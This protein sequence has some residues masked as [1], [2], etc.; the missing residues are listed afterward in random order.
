MNWDLVIEAAGFLIGLYYL[1]LEYH[2]DARLW[3]VSLIMPC[4]SMWIYFS[5]GIYADFAINIYYLLIAFYGYWAW[6]RHKNKKGVEK[7]ALQVSHVPWRMWVVIVSATVVIWAFL[8]WVL[9]RFTDSK[10]P[11]ADGF[12]TAL[13]IVAMWMMSRKYA[14]QWLAWVVVDAVSMC[15][16][17]YKGLVF[18]PVLY[19]IYTVIAVFGYRKWVGMIPRDAK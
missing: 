6:T 16:Y 18:Y 17:L 7:K 3:I 5:K 4:I 10:V 14:E 11:L 19:A 1:W 12:T 2:A 9:V 15:L 13:S 8:A